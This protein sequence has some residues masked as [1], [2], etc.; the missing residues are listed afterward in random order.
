[1]SDAGETRVGGYILKGGTGVYMLLD[2]ETEDPRV[3]RD[4][5]DDRLHTG[6]S[7]SVVLTANDDGKVH[8]DEESDEA[9]MFIRQHYREAEA[10]IELAN[11]DAPVGLQFTPDEAE[12][13]AFKLLEL[14]ALARRG[15]SDGGRA[16]RTVAM[17]GALALQMARIRQLGQVPSAGVPGM[18]PRR[19][20][21]CREHLGQRAGEPLQCLH[22][23]HR[24]RRLPRTVVAAAQPRLPVVV[25][26]HDDLRT[27][28]VERGVLVTTRVQHLLHALAAHLVTSRSCSRAFLTSGTA[29]HGR[30]PV[31]M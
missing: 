19:H 1:M 6:S 27:R 2:P 26:Q 21:A 13:Y 22:T 4:C 24:N 30:V 20:I 3:E 7:R 23:A 17:C 28:E 5:Y 8:V 10:R 25:G 9:R 11:G 12:E 14:A 16:P 15:Q 29:A 31:R 18:V